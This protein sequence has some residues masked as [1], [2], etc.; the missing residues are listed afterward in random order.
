VDLRLQYKEEP[1]L[2]FN[3][4][5]AYRLAGN[6]VKAKTLY[7]RYLTVLPSAPNRSEV[8]AFIGELTQTIA[9]SPAPAAP[10]AI[11]TTEKKKRSHKRK[12]IAGDP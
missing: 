8:E 4:A 2:L 12:A 11:A 9:M 3:I 10:A 6:V 1:A 5:Q 7:E